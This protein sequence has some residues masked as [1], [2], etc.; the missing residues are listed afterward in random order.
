MG[1]HRPNP[2]SGFTSLPPAASPASSCPRRAETPPAHT[3]SPPPPSETSYADRASLDRPPVP[4]SQTPHSTTCPGSGSRPC[5]TRSSPPGRPS[6]G[7]P[8]VPPHDAC[9]QGTNARIS[10]NAYA[11]SFACIL[12]SRTS[13]HPSARSSRAMAD[14]PAPLGCPQP[15]A[16]PNCAPA[17]K[18]IQRAVVTTPAGEVREDAPSRE[19]FEAKPAAWRAR[20]VSRR[21]WARSRPRALRR[22]SA[23]GTRAGKA[24][25]NR[26]SPPVQH[27][28]AQRSLGASEQY[29]RPPP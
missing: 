6:A 21:A 9:G 4:S 26:S 25:R 15:R 3:A 13:R 29:R 20:A 18:G 17:P 7:A 10:T 23:N 24:R 22:S 12:N 8:A 2:F 16:L 14:R 5:A 28:T 27:M 11:L 1:N 19:S